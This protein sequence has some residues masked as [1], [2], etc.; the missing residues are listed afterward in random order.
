VLCKFEEATAKSKT[1]IH[2]SVNDSGDFIQRQPKSTG[3]QWLNVPL[4]T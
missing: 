3:P 1:S 4:L 2:K